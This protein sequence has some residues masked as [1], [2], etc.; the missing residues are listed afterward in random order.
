MILEFFTAVLLLGLLVRF[1][2]QRLHLRAVAR[3]KRDGSP[4]P[5]PPAPF[6]TLAWTLILIAIATGGTVLAQALGL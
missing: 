2:L 3:S 5:I 1:I 4:A 6:E